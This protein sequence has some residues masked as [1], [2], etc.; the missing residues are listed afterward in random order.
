[1]DSYPEQT[2][3]RYDEDNYGARK[4]MPS[5]EAPMAAAL[6]QLQAALHRAEK[7]WEDLAMRLGKV[8]SQEERD[9]PLAVARDTVHGS[10]P[11]LS[12]LVEATGQVERW[13]D[14]I[15]RA[16]GRLEL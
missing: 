6:A 1:M 7:A 10:S 13:N 16:A 11:L 14:R 4:V 3:A 12:E 5:P 15:R 9:D 2:S 8:L